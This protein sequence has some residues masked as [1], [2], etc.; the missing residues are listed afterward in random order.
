M[1]PSQKAAADNAKFDAAMSTA[2]SGEHHWRARMRL[3]IGPVELP[4]GCLITP[5]E[6]KRLAPEKL[7]ML[8]STGAVVCLVGPPPP[9]SEEKVAAIVHVETTP[10]QAK[11][12]HEAMIDAAI[13]AGDPPWLYGRAPV[14]GGAYGIAT[15]AI[16]KSRHDQSLVSDVVRR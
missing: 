11:R 6:I 12:E 8:V 10:D 13:A 14:P 9:A 2:S 16:E 1:N 5:E 7:R 4:R 15:P 3:R